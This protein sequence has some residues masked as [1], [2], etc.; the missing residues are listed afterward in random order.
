MLLQV[1][2][3]RA[4]LTLDRRILQ[5]LV[6]LTGRSSLVGLYVSTLRQCH[7]R[8]GN[9]CRREPSRPPALTLMLASA[10]DCHELGPAR[11]RWSQTYRELL[12]PTRCMVLVRRAGVLRT[13]QVS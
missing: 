7:P 6:G 2:C 10:S 4:S 1:L 9:K 12:V 8:R 13:R 5:A 3:G 11:E